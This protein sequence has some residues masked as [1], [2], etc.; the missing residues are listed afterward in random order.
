[1]NA[2]ERAAVTSRMSEE[3]RTHVVRME[4]L[5]DKPSWDEDDRKMAEDHANAAAERGTY[6]HSES[7]RLRDLAGPEVE[8]LRQATGMGR[9]QAKQLAFKMAGV[10]IGI[11]KEL[12]GRLMAIAALTVAFAAED[13]PTPTDATTQDDADEA[14]VRE[15]T[16]KPIEDKDDQERTDTERLIVDPDGEI[17]R[18]RGEP[19]NITDRTDAVPDK[20]AHSDTDPGMGPEQTAGETNNMST[21]DQ[22]PP[23][24]HQTLTQ[25]TPF[26]AEEPPDDIEP[27]ADEPNPL[28][29]A[30]Q[31]GCIRLMTINVA[32]WAWPSDY[33]LALVLSRKLES[34][35]HGDAPTSRKGEAQ[36]LAT[37][38][39]RAND[40]RKQ[41]LTR[42][43]DEAITPLFGKTE[44]KVARHLLGVTD[45]MRFNP[46][47]NDNGNAPVRAA[48]QRWMAETLIHTHEA[49][50][51]WTNDALAWAKAAAP[52]LTRNTG[53]RLQE[54]TAA[55]ERKKQADAAKVQLSASMAAHTT[56]Q[57]TQAQPRPFGDQEPHTQPPQRTDVKRPRLAS[58]DKTVSVHKPFPR[59]MIALA[60]L[61][62]AAVAGLVAVMIF[63][64]QSWM[65][66]PGEREQATEQ[67]HVTP[68]TPRPAPPQIQPAPRPTLPAEV[69]VRPL[70]PAD[71]GIPGLTNMRRVP[72]DR[73]PL[74]ILY[75]GQLD[76]GDGSNRSRPNGDGTADYSRCQWRT[77]RRPGQSEQ[78]PTTSATTTP[79]AIEAKPQ[80]PAA[81][82]VDDGEED[83]PSV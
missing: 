6:W 31:E 35:H 80:R 24:A 12:R 21:D 73:I 50:S 78:A 59:G 5:L 76:C 15:L 4:A 7:E 67:P 53:R 2:S 25:G 40:Y 69:S 52:H 60:I 48:W 68:P 71:F 38:L 8:A 66:A 72:M 55:Q 14:R 9:K 39:E 26:Q 34:A 28:S 20:L 70:R 81:Q 83:G 32:E 77:V 57:F 42:L 23:K 19:A 37:R 54:A 75:G 29:Y 61:G 46:E 41:T 62:M 65:L 45:P 11:Q 36:N 30:E 82:P 17:R 74:P 79:A 43:A 27:L 49:G 58:D 33:D 1:M 64:F 10:F 3:D 47:V 22:R 56:T 63:L 13:A 51:A 44:R 16:A 18:D